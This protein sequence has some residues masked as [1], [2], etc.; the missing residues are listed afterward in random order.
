MFRKGDFAARLHLHREVQLPGSLSVFHQIVEAANQ[1]E[2]S[3]YLKPCL[4][5]DFPAQRIRQALAVLDMAA[6]QFV[7]SPEKVVLPAAL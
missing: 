4:L 1:A 3:V 5:L 7:E 6:G 2:Y